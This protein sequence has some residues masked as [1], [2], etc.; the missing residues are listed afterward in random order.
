VFEG[1]GELKDKRVDL[2]NYVAVIEVFKH[3]QLTSIKNH[4][5]EFMSAQPN[6]CTT[7]HVFCTHMVE[8][9]KK[10]QTDLTVKG[11]QTTA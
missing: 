5:F 10:M 1:G 6:S 8:F 4:A 9:V 7:V 3:K 11:F 2:D